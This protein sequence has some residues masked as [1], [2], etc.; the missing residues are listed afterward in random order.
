[1]L[2]YV[3]YRILQ[4]IP[5]LF[6]ISVI[7]FIIIQL[8]PGDFLSMYVEQL[9][10]SGNDVDESMILN[11]TAQYGLDKPL[12]V[13]YYIWMKNIILHADFGTSFQYKLPVSVII[14]ERLMLT[15][16]ISIISLIIIWLI[17]IPIGIYSSTHQYS[18]LDYV[19]SFIGFIGL[20]VP[21]F[22]IALILIYAVYAQTGVAITG[23][24]SPEYA[25]AP[26]SLAKVWDMAPRLI[27]PVVIIGL[28]G[29]AALIRITR[30][31]MLD[32]LSKQYVTTARAKGVGETKLLWKYPVRTAINPL[33][34]TIGWTL[35]TL[36]S[37]EAI[38]SIVLNLPTTG[39]I[40]L[41]ALMV[42]DMYLAGSFILIL[43]VL[44]V[45]G[46][47]LSDILL[48][49]LDPRIRYGGARS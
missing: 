35:P 47:L 10:L 5:L 1:M 46:T 43:S 28:S 45:L 33:I 19:F 14:G 31:M 11:L 32:E 41:N 26:W 8:P 17:S 39:P 21:G 24:F 38:V 9:R 49:V 27:I 13:Q 23:L 22:L 25:D 37:G 15:M 48:A 7:V 6:A 16:V 18:P 42:Q 2:Q 34:S 3:A 4:M 36:I 12:H 29:T 44:T 30:G 40:L 20:A